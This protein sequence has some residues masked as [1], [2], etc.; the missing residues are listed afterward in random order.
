[1]F[2]H[3]IGFEQLLP[4]LLSMD[5][6]SRSPELPFKFTGGFGFASSTIG[7]ILSLQGVYQMA[8][9]MIIFPAVVHR[10]GPLKT[11]RFT[12]FV[13]PLLYF[14]T[15]YISLMPSA[16]RI[17]GL[18][19]VLVGKVTFQALSYPSNMLILTDAAPSLLVLGFV[20]GVAASAASLARAIGPTVAGLIQSAGL[21][22]GYLGL[23]W[24]ASGAVAGI[25]AIQCLWI[26]YPNRRIDGP[27]GMRSSQS[28]ENA[29]NQNQGFGARSH[30]GESTNQGRR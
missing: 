27:S 30:Q 19:T 18:F 13:Y 2:S 9:Q 7:I 28:A 21:E 10:F 29:S 11:F 26:R 3:T 23:S 12:A 17:F 22:L 20:N 1:M 4:V 25:G 14:V 6:P 8:A 16:L 24:W 5:E 15:P